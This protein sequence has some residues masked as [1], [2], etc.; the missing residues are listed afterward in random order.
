MTKETVDT[1]LDRTEN[2][3]TLTFSGGEPVLN[4]K[5]II[6][7]IDEII[8]R[9]I[10]VNSFYLVTNAGVFNKDLFFK[11]IEFYHY[12]EEKEY[13][14]VSISFDDYHDEANEKYV[15]RWES[16]S[17][18]INDKDQRENFRFDNSLITEGYALKYGIGNRNL[19]LF[20]EM[21]VDDLNYFIED[22]YVNAKGEITN[23]C[24]M[25]YETQEEHVQGTVNDIDAI[26][27]KHNKQ[28]EK[29]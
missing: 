9:S 21:E 14:F 29:V 24:N 15:E 4:A 22:F 7:I 25:S 18:Y 10:E 2:I 6:Y 11:L 16:L 8:S 1:L 13:S 27:N 28:V 19:N 3:G 17:F 23:N 5:L 20:D 12:V 26:F